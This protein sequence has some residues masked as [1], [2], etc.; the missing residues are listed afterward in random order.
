MMDRLSQDLENYYAKREKYDEQY[1]ECCSCG[2]CIDADWYY[3]INNKF[4]CEDC[5]ND[6]F[7]NDTDD[8]EA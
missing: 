7:R 4:Y 2:Q 6:L 8:Y 3:E 5:L 1:P